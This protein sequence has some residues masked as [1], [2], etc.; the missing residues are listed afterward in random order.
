MVY[1]Y[2]PDC[3]IKNVWGTV[4]NQ[5]TSHLKC[6]RMVMSVQESSHVNACQVNSNINNNKE[7]RL[8]Y[9]KKIKNK[10]K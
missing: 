6:I 7:R 10:N 1:V 2:W 4:R 8:A 5:V 9:S 3:P